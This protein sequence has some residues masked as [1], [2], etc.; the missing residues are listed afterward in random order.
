VRRSLEYLDENGTLVT[1]SLR[2]YSRKTI[3]RHYASLDQFLHR[4]QAAE[5]KEAII[6]ELAE[7]G[8]LLDPLLEEVG[9]DLDPFDLICHIAFDQPPLTRR[10]RVANVRKRDVFTQYGS[11]ARAVLE[12]L[13]DKYQDDGVVT[14]LADPRL[15]QIAPFASM[16]TVPQLIKHFGT[17]VDFERAVHALQTA[18]Y[19]ESA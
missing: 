18:L 13:L 16:G 12:A 4:W 3:R 1:E 5:R 2:D 19:Q 7:E 15:L 6:A 17:R 11:Q 8:L 14:G 9:K 10:D